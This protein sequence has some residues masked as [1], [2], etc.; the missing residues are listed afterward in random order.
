MAGT[1][2]YAV[3][4]PDEH[5]DAARHALGLG[6]EAQP[7]EVLRR[8]LATVSGLPLPQLRTGRPRKIETVIT[9]ER[10]SA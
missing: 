1:P 9:P 6:P 4:V 2:L 8:C 7:T 10:Q 5:M 3:R